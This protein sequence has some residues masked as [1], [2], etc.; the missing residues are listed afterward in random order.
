MHPHR[1]TG[2]CC[3]KDHPLSNIARVTIAGHEAVTEV[4][5]VTSK[6]FLLLPADKAQSLCL[7]LAVDIDQKLLKESSHLQYVVALSHHDVVAVVLQLCEFLSI[8]SSSSPGHQM[9]AGAIC[10]IWEHWDTGVHHK[11]HAAH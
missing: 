1:P 9:D 4:V 8:M 2:V 6:Q 7:D 11:M 3:W 10:S 5:E